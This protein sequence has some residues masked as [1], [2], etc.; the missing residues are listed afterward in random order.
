MNAPEDR[1]DAAEARSEKAEREREP[2][3]VG[4][5]EKP[6]SSPSILISAAP[7]SASRGCDQ[8]CLISP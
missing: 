5:D 8:V 7:P 1:A 4:R 3:P 2:A 6:P